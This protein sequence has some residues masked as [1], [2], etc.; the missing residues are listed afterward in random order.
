MDPAKWQK[1]KDLVAA[2][3]ELPDSER[4]AALVREPDVEIREE[5]IKLV[6]SHEHAGDFID[7]PILIEREDEESPDEYIGQNVENYKILERI[8]TGGMGAVY[9]AERLNSDFKQKVA[10]KLIKRGMDSE[11]ILKRFERERRILSSLRHPNIAQLIDGGISSEGLPYFVMEYVEGKP[12]NQF[13]REHGLNLNERLKIIRQI[14]EAVE[15][16]HKNL[17]IHRDLKPSNIIVTDE[18]VPKLLDFGIAKLLT[19]DDSESTNTA[20]LGRLF[21]PEYASPE[22]I[23]GNK[24]TTATDVYS[25]GVILYELLTQHRPFDLKGKS[26]EEVVENVCRTEPTRPSD[27]FL[28]NVITKEFEQPDGQVSQFQLRG[29]LDNIALKALRKEPSERYGSVHQLSEDIR[30]YLSGLPVLARPQTAFYRFGKYFRRHRIVVLTSAL[31]LVSLISGISVAGWQAVVANRERAKAEERFEDVRQLANKILFDHYERIK[32]LPGATE[33]RARLVTD[34][35]LYLDKISQDSDDNPD[36]QRDL[37][38]AYRKLADIQGST[39][40]GGNLGDES[41]ARINLLKALKIGEKLVSGESATNDDKKN[42]G[43]IYLDISSFFELENERPAQAKYVDSA[44]AIFQALSDQNPDTASS[45]ADLAKALWYKANIVRLH[46]DNHGSIEAYK[47]AESI[48]SRLGRGTEKPELYR[49]NAALTR[50]NLGTIYL[51]ENDIRNARKYFQL[52]FDF[53]KA[54]SVASPANAEVLMD[55]SFSHKSLGEVYLKSKDFKKSIEHFRQALQIQESIA[56]RDPKNSFATN[57]IFET[58]ASLG[59]AFADSGDLSE[60]ENA[61]KKCESE[62]S[63]ILSKTGN[64][65]DQSVTARFLKVYGDFYLKKAQLP[66]GP[67]VKISYLEQAKE[68]F[69]ASRDIFGKMES[70]KTLDPA[71]KNVFAEVIEAFK[72]TE[73]EISKLKRV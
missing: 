60:A 8:G 56:A 43:K 17:V 26:Y 59:N 47:Q 21:T 53:D 67:G 7:K 71:F 63:N 64:N 54:N 22:Q 30:R 50:K 14:C 48:Y 72:K 6:H 51:L 10:I 52:A 38:D 12:L 39:V 65:H 62:L 61:F 34:A 9:L 15:H 66:A 28:K 4:E 20:N 49:R 31:G 16:A 58:N 13:C 46:G 70:E 24:V 57:A 32:N 69:R 1:I 44:L 27:T 68:R 45:Q 36:L 25:L 18:M 33:A 35:L 73:T 40:Q 55:L 11:A 23:L 42:L 2:V 37:I 41:G 19:D 3:L 29:D 5:A